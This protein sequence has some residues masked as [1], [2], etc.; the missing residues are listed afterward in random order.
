LLSFIYI[1]NAHKIPTQD[2]DG[3]LRVKTNGELENLIEKEIL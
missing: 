3:A 2:N 1:S